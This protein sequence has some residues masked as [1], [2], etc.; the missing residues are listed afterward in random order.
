[1]GGYFLLFPK[2]KID[3][4][5]IFIIIFRVIPVS[6][7]IM[8]GAWFAFQLVAGF[9]V[10]ADQGGVAYWAHSGGFVIGLVLTV[11]LWLMRGG[12]RYWDRTDGHPPHP[13]VEYA[14]DR[15]NVPVVRRK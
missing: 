1:M 11:P 2:A 10:D 9:T 5:F 7:W 6:A 4:L 8:L 15:S 14:I 13:E 3:I 12:K